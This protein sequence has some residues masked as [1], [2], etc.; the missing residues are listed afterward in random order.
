MH[1]TATPLKNPLLK[2]SRNLLALV[3]FK[4][5]WSE[6][7]SRGTCLLKCLKIF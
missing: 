3:L 1:A 5:F 7:K 2:R 6:A 4:V